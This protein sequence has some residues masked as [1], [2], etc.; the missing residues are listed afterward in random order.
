MALGLPSEHHYWN[1]SPIRSPSFR[2]VSLCF[3]F[4][5]PLEISCS[6]SSWY[7]CIGLPVETSHRLIPLASRLL[8]YPGSPFQRVFIVQR[9]SA[10]SLPWDSHSTQHV[11]EVY[12][13]ENSLCS[14]EKPSDSHDPF[15]SETSRLWATCSL[16]A[17]SHSNDSFGPSLSTIEWSDGYLEMYSQKVIVSRICT[18]IS[19]WKKTLRFNLPEPFWSFILL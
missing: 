16:H 14:S 3:C 18:Y 5:G 15:A 7:H 17:N 13:P 12:S 6:L 8:P 9:G 19:R 11:P 10:K 2:G 4:C 1:Q